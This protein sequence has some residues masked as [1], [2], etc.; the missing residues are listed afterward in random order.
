[1]IPARYQ[2]PR[3]GVVGPGHFALWGS[4]EL[5]LDVLAQSDREL[6]CEVLRRWLLLLESLADA[7]F[8]REME[9]GDIPRGA[10]RAREAPEGDVPERLREV[11]ADAEGKRLEGNAWC[12]VREVTPDYFEVVSRPEGSPRSVLV[13]VHGEP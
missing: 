2:D 6:W 1:M 10:F 9:D 5:A 13:G 11:W 4:G 7:T 8:M 3:R 12:S